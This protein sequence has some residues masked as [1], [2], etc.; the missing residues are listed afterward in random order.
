M[1]CWW[2]GGCVARLSE[3]F[4]S[5]TAAHYLE[6]LY[7]DW[8]EDP[9]SVH[10]SWNAYFKGLAA[11]AP[12]GAAHSKPGDAPVPT[13]SANSEMLSVQQLVRAY[14]AV[15]HSDAGL[16]PLGVRQ[17]RAQAAPRPPL[18]MLELACDS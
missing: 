12:P 13:G 6:E 3:T 1:C 14:Q 17:V 10:P 4:L 16:D 9:S 15:G 2:C 7:L 18:L 8:M 5:G 11:G